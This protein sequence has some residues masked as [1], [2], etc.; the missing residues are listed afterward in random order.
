MTLCRVT[1]TITTTA[2]LPALEKRTL[3]I[4]VPVDPRTK[5]LLRGSAGSELIAVDHVQAGEGDLVL[6]CDEGNAARLMLGDPDAPIR[7]V[8]AAIVDEVE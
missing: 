5:Q 2:K 4:C 7:T 1:G 6:V 3:L 8:V